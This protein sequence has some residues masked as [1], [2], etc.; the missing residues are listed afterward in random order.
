MKLGDLVRSV[1]PEKTYCG[2]IVDEKDSLHSTRVKLIKVLWQ[3]GHESTWSYDQD[4][5]VANESR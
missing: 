5:E 2:I 4:L 1:G 3:D